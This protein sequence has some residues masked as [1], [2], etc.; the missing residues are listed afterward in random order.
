MKEKISVPIHY[1]K[2]KN[3]NKQKIHDKTMIVLDNIMENDQQIIELLHN[4][5]YTLFFISN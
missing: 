2:Q 1:Q 4:K 3:T 5:H